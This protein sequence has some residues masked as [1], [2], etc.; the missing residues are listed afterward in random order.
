MIKVVVFDLD[1]V[2]LFVDHDTF[3]SNFSERFSLSGDLVRKVL[4]EEHLAKGNF[5]DLRCGKVPPEIW[6]QYVFGSLGLEGKATKQDYLEEMVKV[7]AVNDRVVALINTLH[8]QGIRTAV[9]SNNYRDN[10]EFLKQKF[11]LEEY[12]DVMVFSYEVGAMK[13]DPRIFR[14]LVKR[15]G[16][17]PYEIVF[18]DDKADKL[19]GALEVG[20][21]AFVYENFDSYLRKLQE[22]GV[23]VETQP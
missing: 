12:F 23:T 3:V 18:S 16:V 11:D 14:E 1:G 17:K 19:R 21:K 20:I 5:D 22:L 2:F 13:P 9:C 15:A 7:R 4:F 8:K 10:I 6:W